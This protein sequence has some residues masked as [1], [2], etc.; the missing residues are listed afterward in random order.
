MNVSDFLYKFRLPVLSSAILQY[1]YY[2]N[3]KGLLNEIYILSD[4]N[5]LNCWSEIISF[6]NRWPRQDNKIG[7]KV[8]GMD[9]SQLK[10]EDASLHIL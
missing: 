3:Y 6:L 10:D 8:T 2:I 5:L 7:R 1:I 9:W 4:N